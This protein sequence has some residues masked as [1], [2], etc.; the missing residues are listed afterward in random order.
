MLTEDHCTGEESVAVLGDPQRLVVVGVDCSPQ[1]VEPL[2]WADRQAC[3]TGSRLVAVRSW[4]VDLPGVELV[5][6]DDGLAGRTRRVLAW[7]IAEVLGVERS[8]EVILR[9]SGRA[10]ANALVDESRDAELLVVDRGAHMAFV[11]WFSDR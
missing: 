7:T 11:A 10:P 6:A 2:R 3:L 8:R 5:S 4:H 9:V 1:S